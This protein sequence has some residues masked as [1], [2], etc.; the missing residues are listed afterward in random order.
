MNEE[1]TG[2]APAKNV[3][4][5]SKEPTYGGRYFCQIVAEDGEY[6]NTEVQNCLDCGAIV[7]D[8]ERHSLYHAIM[9]ALVQPGYSF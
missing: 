9:Y 7:I 1:R 4:P 3:S 2:V 6:T 8:A 5:I